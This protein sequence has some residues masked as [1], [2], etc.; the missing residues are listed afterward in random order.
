MKTIHISTRWVRKGLASLGS[1]APLL[2]SPT[3]SITRP[4]SVSAT[5][6]LRLT[7]SCRETAALRCCSVMQTWSYEDAAWERAGGARRGG[8]P[9]RTLLANERTSATR[10]GRGKPSPYYTRVG[11]LARPS[12]ATR[13][14]RGKPSPYY[15][16]VGRL[17]RPS[18]V[19]ATL[20]VAQLWLP[21]TSPH[22]YTSI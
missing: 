21:L 16:R 1:P 12:R 5:C 15:T 3:P 18:R 13:Q 9:S 7:S 22:I 10:Q 8:R 17:A 2:L 14:G 11:R 20:A 19:G 6:R 4:A